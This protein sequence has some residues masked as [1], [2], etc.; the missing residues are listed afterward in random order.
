MV[1][2]LSYSWL[3]TPTQCLSSLPASRCRGC[4]ILNL[5]SQPPGF[6]GGHVTEYGLWGKQESLLGGKEAEI[7]GKSFPPWIK[8]GK[9]VRS[10][11]LAM[12]TYSLYTTSFVYDCMWLWY[13]KVWPP[14]C[15]H[16]VTSQE[17]EYETWKK[18]TMS[19][20]TSLNYKNLPQEEPV[21]ELVKQ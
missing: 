12:L 3:A 20:V 9:Q 1:I 15:D 8:E 14:S 10:G 5:P 6:R 11:L 13:V 16:E 19:L 4:K 2:I 21:S 17:A 18:G 7:L